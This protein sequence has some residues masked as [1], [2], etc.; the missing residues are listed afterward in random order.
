MIN[1][2]IREKILSR[3]TN[4]GRS[5]ALGMLIDTAQKI[6][7]NDNRTTEN[8]DISKAA[9]K[10]TKEAIKDI[11]LFGEQSKEACKLTHEIEVYKEF[12]PKKL[13]EEQIRDLVNKSLANYCGSSVSKNDYQNIKSHLIKELKNTEGMDMQILMSVI[14]SVL[15]DL[16]I[17]IST[18]ESVFNKTK[19]VVE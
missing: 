2:L 12:L 14:E 19:E 13:N 5:V 15:K 17:L 10:L 7:K 6:A 11:Q 4:V 9:E 1:N 16:S 8:S 3:K 18:I